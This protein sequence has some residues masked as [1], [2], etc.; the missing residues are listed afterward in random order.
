MYTMYGSGYSK[1]SKSIRTQNFHTYSIECELNRLQ[2]MS[3]LR[4]I[5]KYPKADVICILCMTVRHEQSERSK[6]S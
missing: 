3:I 5:P 1:H 4:R 2:Y 6:R